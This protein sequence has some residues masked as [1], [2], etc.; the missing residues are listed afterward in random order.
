[1]VK[2]YNEMNDVEKLEFEEKSIR[3]LDITTRQIELL[4]GSSIFTIGQ[5]IDIKG[6]DIKKILNYTATSYNKV[7]NAIGIYGIQF[8]RDKKGRVG[9]S[10]FSQNLIEPVDVQAMNKVEQAKFLSSP[11]AD[12]GFSKRVVE[13]LTKS[14][15]ETIGD[16]I[17]TERVKIKMLFNKN[18]Y[19]LSK[20]DDT[21]ALYNLKFKKSKKVYGRES[22]LKPIDV[23][24]V[25]EDERKE[26]LNRSIEDIGIPEKFIK[27]FKKAG[28]LTLG[29]IAKSKINELPFANKNQLLVHEIEKILDDY[30]LPKD[31]KIFTSKIYPRTLDVQDIRLLPEKEKKEYLRSNIQNLG[32][33]N[34]IVN[35]LKLF[36]IHKVQDFYKYKKSEIRYGSRISTPQMVE[37]ERE[38]N[39]YGI[40]LACS[41]IK[42]VDGN[43]IRQGGAGKE[44]EYSKRK[45][46]IDEY[47]SYTEE[48]KQQFLGRSVGDLGIPLKALS[49][50]KAAKIKTIGDLLNTSKNAAMNALNRNITLTAALTKVLNEYGLDYYKPREM[51]N[52]A[53]RLK[54]MFD[55]NTFDYLELPQDTQTMLREKVGVQTIGELSKLTNKELLAGLDY[56]LDSA[57]DIY[58]AMGKHDIILRH[59]VAN[60]KKERPNGFGVVTTHSEDKYYYRQM[61]HYKKYMTYIKA[62]NREQVQRDFQD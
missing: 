32:L 61:N 10:A 36:G 38:L 7:K 15:I 27:A 1:M 62:R 26:I 31:I 30:N 35:V 18:M 47:A 33:D 11:V 39:D 17:N 5:L 29:D 22:K 28:V 60:M 2:Q 14:G 51:P 58:K 46:N 9:D 48:E 49:N 6:S 34:G 25:S 55:N 44:Y 13:I 21:L 45:V 19:L 20:M 3:T 24:N 4:E 40:I 50:L 53:Q 12:L 54:N 57:Y 37:L 52:K 43:Y 16:F 59:K 41:N 56:D 42:F 8:K 23:Y